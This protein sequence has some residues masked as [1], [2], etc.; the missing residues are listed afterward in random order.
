MRSGA[1]DCIVVDSVAA[2]V[3]KAEI[4]GMMGDST[5]VSGPAH[6]PGAAKLTA[7]ISN[8]LCHHLHQPA[9]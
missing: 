2:M 3:P 9:A 1:I 5:W 7:V 6:V 8:Q 4:E